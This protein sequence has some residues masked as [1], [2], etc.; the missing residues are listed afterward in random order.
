[1]ACGS[2]SFDEEALDLVTPSDS[3]QDLST[4][5]S[6]TSLMTRSKADYMF[7]CIGNPRITGT[8]SSNCA[9]G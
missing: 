8:Y 6:W 1:M 3:L 9:V 7:D 4:F 2:K 5:S